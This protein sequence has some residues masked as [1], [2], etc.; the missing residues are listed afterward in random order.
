[1]INPIVDV[2]FGGQ[3]GSEGKRLFNE[4]YAAETGPDAIISNFGPNSGGFVSDGGKWATFAAGIECIHM[5]SPGSIIDLDDFEREIKNLPDGTKVVVHENACV[6]LP[7]HK[8]QEKSL[9]N[10]GSTMTGTMAAVVQKMQRIPKNQNIARYHLH[11]YAINNARWFAMMHNCKRIQ[12]S[13][14]QGHSLS[15]NYGMSPYCTSRNTSPQQALADAGIPIQWVDKIIACMR[16][17]PIRVSNRYDDSGEMIGYSG[18]CYPDQHEMT[19]EEVGQPPEMTSV[20]KKVRRVFSFSPRQYLESCLMNGVTDV[21]INFMNYLTKQ[22][23]DG[24]FK[25]LTSY[26]IPNVSWMGYGP[27]MTDIAKV[28][29]L[30]PSDNID[31]REGCHPTMFET[32]ER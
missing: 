2:I 11:K 15:L 23:A 5:L 32:G 17:F 8:E 6:V 22:E 12:L 16:T 1:M 30:T 9:V 7:E 18:P 14:P 29:L 31:G 24:L 10:I 19:W 3:F 25:S 26:G 20:S 27:T 28:K 4:Y 21:F 13:V